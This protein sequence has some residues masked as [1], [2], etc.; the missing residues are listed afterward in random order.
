[1]G[2]CRRDGSLALAQGRVAAAQT[3]ASEVAGDT[4]NVV[5]S[6]TP[7]GVRTRM[8]VVRPPKGS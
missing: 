7:I 5:V 4:L 1:V 3:T 6:Q 8:T 2:L